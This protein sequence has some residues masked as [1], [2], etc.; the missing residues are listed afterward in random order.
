ML[1][2]G[3]MLTE[4]DLIGVLG[5]DI[6]GVLVE[7]SRSGCL[8]ETPFRVDAGALGMLRLVMGGN[9]YGDAV[10]IARCQ[11]LPGAGDRFHL[12]VE[13]VWLDAPEE[14]S[15]RRLASAFGNAGCPASARTGVLM[16]TPD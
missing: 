15:I 12:G 16:G 9:E 4:P 5:R 10:R 6:T 11:A 8:L 13:F 14:H 3:A 7:I 1:S 2:L